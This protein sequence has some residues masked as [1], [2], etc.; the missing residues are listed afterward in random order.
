MIAE[1]P[2]LCI[3]IVEY[4]DNSTVL[5]D[6]VIAHRLGLIPLKSS[7]KMSSWQYNHACDCEAYC[8]ACSAL[9]TLDCSFESLAAKRGLN[10]RDVVAL[11][12]S[13]QDLQCHNMYVQTCDYSSER[14]KAESRDGLGIAIVTLGPGQRIKLEA[15]AKKGIA[16]EHAKWSPVCTVAL[17]YD[18]IVK[19]NE[20]ALSQ[21]SE[22]QKAELA[23]CCPTKVFS[24]DGSAAVFIE[25]GDESRCIFCKECIFTAE[26]F[27]PSPEDSLAVSVTH[28]ANKFTFTVETTGA[29]T[30]KEVVSDAL[31]ILMGKLSKLSDL[32]LRLG[33]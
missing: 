14:D 28:A 8:D 17:K 12:V 19:L 23:E 20:E 29:L 32:N 31:D 24:Y 7:R 1:V 27:R 2:T 30:A 13:S 9:L 3:D 25:R 22:K 4:H 6:E 5:T 11:T 16:K 15:I 33:K 21:Y 18:P 26:E 10:P